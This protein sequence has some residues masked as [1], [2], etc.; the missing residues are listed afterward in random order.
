[1]AITCVGILR[2]RISRELTPNS[3]VIHQIDCALSYFVFYMHRV[4]IYGLL[5]M[6][7][8][9]NGTGNGNSLHL[10]SGRLGPTLIL[11]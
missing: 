3:L 4:G 2:L 8:G 1:M 6:T 7:L 11:L 10:H 5:I 9:V